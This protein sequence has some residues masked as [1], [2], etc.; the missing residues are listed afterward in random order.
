MDIIRKTISSEASHP[1]F[2]HDFY[3]DYTLREWMLGIPQGEDWFADAPRE[4][5][6]RGVYEWDR[7]HVYPVHGGGEIV[8]G[9]I[10]HHRMPA[11]WLVEGIVLSG[12][13]GVISPRMGHRART[14]LSCNLA[15]AM[16]CG[17]PW[18]ILAGKDKR[19]GKPQTW[20]DEYS[21]EN[22]VSA[23]FGKKNHTPLCN[24]NMDG[25]VLYLAGNLEAAQEQISKALSGLRK[26]ELEAFEHNFTL[27]PI[28][29]STLDTEQGI[30]KIAAEIGIASSKW[31]ETLRAHAEHE[32]DDKLRYQLPQAVF[33]DPHLPATSLNVADIV[34]KTLNG[35]NLE[36]QTT[37]ST[38]EWCQVFW[39]GDNKRKWSSQSFS[40]S[41]DHREVEKI[42]E[43]Q[44]E[45]YSTLDD[46][47]P[48]ALGNTSRT[49]DE[50]IPPFLR[51]GPADINY[52]NPWVEYAEVGRE[53]KLFNS[54]HL[55]GTDRM[56]MIRNL[57]QP[58]TTLILVNTDEATIG[59]PDFQLGTGED[60]TKLEVYNEHFPSPFTSEAPLTIQPH[61]S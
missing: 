57:R 46:E 1:D 6:P 13:L 30:S 8:V 40:S 11:E 17:T 32:E 15:V 50:D 59:K 25:R 58:G 10:E 34:F 41:R 21:F 36:L 4:P 53:P 24:I 54:R 22:R 19:T 38:G 26:Q 23:F 20:D 33:Y 12:K 60:Q 5:Q 29:S 18:P 7:R 16:A 52:N 47:G 37:S 28:G 56:K 14:A 39:L 3:T 55:K 43:M 48:D 49:I 2:S 27:A 51:K 45:F 9:K 42:V 31:T 35:G 44:R 61:S